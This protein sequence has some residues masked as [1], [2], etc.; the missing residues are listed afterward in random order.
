MTFYE[1]ERGMRT[2]VSEMATD[3]MRYLTDSVVQ[4]ERVSRVATI[5]SPD[6][7]RVEHHLFGAPGIQPGGWP[8]IREYTKE[9]VNNARLWEHQPKGSTQPDKRII[10]TSTANK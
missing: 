7:L 1:R 4:G 6:I 9:Q 8:V 10:W 5:V 3:A 2:P